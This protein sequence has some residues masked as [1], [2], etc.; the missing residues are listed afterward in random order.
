MDNTTLYS[1]SGNWTALAGVIAL[2][3]SKLGVNATVD[4]ILAIIG[5]VVALVG[6]VK[7]YLAH[8]KL[9]VTMGAIRA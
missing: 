7:Q 2:V 9:A 3:L 5:G 4:T 6:I 8:K 1:Q